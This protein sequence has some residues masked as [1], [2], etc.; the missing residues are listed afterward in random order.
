[1]G[2]AGSLSL[3]TLHSLLPHRCA[4]HSAAAPRAEA[5]CSLL[6]SETQNLIWVCAVRPFPGKKP[7][8]KA[9]KQPEGALLVSLAGGG[10]QVRSV[11]SPR[12]QGQDKRRWPQLCPGWPGWTPGKIPALNAAEPWHRLPRALLHSPPLE[13][14][15]KGVGTGSQRGLVGTGDSAEGWAGWPWRSLAASVIL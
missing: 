8:W 6:V 15:G 2:D 12:E 7:P 11:C 10:R 14:L 3:L 13:L 5:F 4:L 1:M 9:L